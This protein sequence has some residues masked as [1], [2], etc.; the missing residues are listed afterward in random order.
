LW[1]RTSSIADHINREHKNLYLS[2]EE[3][4][5]SVVATSDLRQA[6]KDS[7]YIVVVVPS[8]GI[9]SLARELSDA[10]TPGQILINASKGIDESGVTLSKVLLKPFENRDKPEL[11]VLSGPSFAIEVVKGHPTTV[12]AACESLATAE[13]VQNVISHENF[14]VYTQE[15]V[16]GTEVGGAVKNVIAIA[17]GMVQ[18]LGFGTNTLAALITRGL[19]EMTRLATLLGGQRETLMGLSGVGDLVLTCTSEISRN[20]NVG[21]EV[22]QG[23]PLKEIV[24]GMREVAEGIR[25]TKAVNLLSEKLNVE[26]PITRKVYEVLF[27]E[28]KPMEALEDLLRRPLRHEFEGLDD[29]GK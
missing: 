10:Y 29:S 5:A 3:I 18:G 28:R 15:D 26:M 23:R 4:P 6:V 22:G 2:T 16:T 20:R 27:E 21:Y 19:S 13:R 24:E 9:Q 11:V 7:E 17:A 12:V 8:H 1:S 14:R 25:T